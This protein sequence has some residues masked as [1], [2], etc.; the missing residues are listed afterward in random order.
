ML[1]LSMKTRNYVT[2]LKH[3]HLVVERPTHISGYLI[4]HFYIQQSFYNKV[5]IHSIVKSVYF[6]TM[7]Q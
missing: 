7:M 2:G 3:Y 1:I 5:E 6:Q 4:D